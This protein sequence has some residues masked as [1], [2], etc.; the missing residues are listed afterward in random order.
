MSTR[1]LSERRVK[2]GTVEDAD[3]EAN[4]FLIPTSLCVRLLL[5][6]QDH[7]SVNPALQYEF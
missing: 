6:I 5:D 7:H 3:M 1:V 4:L 2:L